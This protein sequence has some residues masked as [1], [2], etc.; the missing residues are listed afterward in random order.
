ML[1]Y[2]ASDTQTLPGK[3]RK[4][5]P[6]TYY[7]HSQTTSFPS[8]THNSPFRRKQD[9]S[10][11]LIE[12]RSELQ[13]A[14]SKPPV[15]SG[16]WRSRLKFSKCLHLTIFFP[17]G[18]ST[19]FVLRVEAKGATNSN[20]QKATVIIQWVG[21]GLPHTRPEGQ[22]PLPSPKHSFLGL[23]KLALPKKVQKLPSSSSLEEQS[24]NAL[25]SKSPT[26]GAMEGERLNSKEQTVLFL[27]HKASRSI[28]KKPETL[29][30][31]YSCLQPDI[32]TKI[33]SAIAI[34]S[35]EAFKQIKAKVPPS[36]H[37]QPVNTDTHIHPKGFFPGSKLG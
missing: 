1:L 11:Q 16:N 13:Q 14:L 2:F 7:L 19:N 35:L 15:G 5:S 4:A 29:A 33:P 6:D 17:Y 30:P 37:S 36:H 8:L 34:K 32:Y 28:S 3:G 21:G 18:S 12:T 22:I 23:V 31:D 26:Q 20:K 25:Q 27:Y 10:S 24:S 9:P